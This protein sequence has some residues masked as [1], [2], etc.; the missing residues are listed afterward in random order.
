[1]KKISDSEALNKAASYCTLCERCTSEVRT[2]L[3]TWGIQPSSQK[4]IIDRLIDEGFINEKRYCKAFVNDKLRFNHWGRIKI[5]AML[6]E[7][8]L[9][10]ELIKEV[11]DEIDETEYMHILTS[12]IENKRKEQKAPE[13][14]ANK[15]KLIR[16]AAS[17]GF[18]PDKIMQIINLGHYE[19]DF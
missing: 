1:M 15:Q 16:F 12:V 9:P 8:K 17:R 19:M 10:H 2:K 14:Y 13:E 3:T 5:T 11:T 6:R 7:K 18:E 4:Q